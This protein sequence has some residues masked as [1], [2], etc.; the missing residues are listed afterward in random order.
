M[1][2]FIFYF[3]V[4]EKQHLCDIE[5]YSCFLQRKRKM[6]KIVRILCIECCCKNI[7]NCRI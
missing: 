7:T 1:Y 6:Q 2:F 5:V 3:F 4:Q